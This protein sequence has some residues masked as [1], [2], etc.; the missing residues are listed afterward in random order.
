MKQ[1]RVSVPADLQP[2]M[3]ENVKAGGNSKAVMKLL[4]PYLNAV[5]ALPLARDVR[6]ELLDQAILARASPDDRIVLRRKKEANR[7]D[8]ELDVVVVRRD[9][10]AERGAALGQ[11]EDGALLVG[12]VQL[13]LL[14]VPFVH[15]DAAAIQTARY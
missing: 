15:S 8:A 11:R 7:H 3:L 5:S 14:S 1:F 2:L 4:N 12:V 9:A 13:G 6:K 10:R